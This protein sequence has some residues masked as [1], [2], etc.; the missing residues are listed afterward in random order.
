[1]TE[2]Q[3]K[4]ILHNNWHGASYDEALR[5]AQYLYNN[6]KMHINDIN[7]TMLRGVEFT[8]KDLRIKE[9]VNIWR[10]FRPDR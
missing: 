4:E 1:M 7:G 3:I 6:Q 2:I 5:W 9:P 10:G 8:E